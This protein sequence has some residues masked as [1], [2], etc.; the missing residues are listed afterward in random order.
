MEAGS[1]ADVGDMAVQR[2][3]LMTTPEVPQFFWESDPFLRSVF[4]RKQSMSLHVAGAALSLKRPSHPIVVPDDEAE[5]PI[6]KAL[7]ASWVSCD[8]AFACSSLERDAFV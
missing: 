6:S 1:A 7:K 8:T 5:T 4:G 2:C 3:S